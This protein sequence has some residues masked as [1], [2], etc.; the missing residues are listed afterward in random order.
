MVFLFLFIAGFQYLFPLQARESRRAMDA[1]PDG[2]GKRPKRGLFSVIKTA[3]LLS[4]AA[5]PWTLCML[6]VTVGMV[7]LTFF[8]RPDGFGT[9]LYLWAFALF[10][11]TAYLHSF[12]LRLAFRRLEQ[13]G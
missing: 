4:A 13:L 10:A 8:L 1:A 3:Y 5:L 9:A 12:F 6:A 7:F 11:V 2:E